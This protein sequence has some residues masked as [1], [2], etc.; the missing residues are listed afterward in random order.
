[1]ASCAGVVARWGRGASN[2]KKK[3]AAK[4]AAAEAHEKEQAKLKREETQR[5]K[6]QATMARSVTVFTKLRLQAG[7]EKLQDIASE[8]DG[9]LESMPNPAAKVVATTS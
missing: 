9:N 7:M 1:M 3:A 4:V 2:T 5:L 8:M 6:R